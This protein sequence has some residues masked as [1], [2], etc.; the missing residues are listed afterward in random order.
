MRVLM[1]RMEDGMAS[2][3]SRKAATAVVLVGLLVFWCG[4]AYASASPSIAGF[5]AAPNPAASGGTVTVSASVSEAGECT[6]S[7]NKP[8][9]GLPVSFSCESGK[10]SQGVAM[11]EN[12]SEKPVK[13]KLTLTATGPGGHAKAHVS[14]SVDPFRPEPIFT[15][16]GYYFKPCGGRRV[17][18]SGDGTSAVWGHCTYSFNGEKWVH[19][20]TL[21]E[22]GR[23]AAIRPL[24]MSGDGR[25][26]VMYY[27][28]NL[29]EEVLDVFTR[30]SEEEEWTLQTMLVPP[31]EYDIP[32]EVALSGNGNTLLIGAF[33]YESGAKP[34]REFD[35]TGETWTEGVP[36]ATGADRCFGVALSGDGQTALLGCNGGGHEDLAFERSG[37]SWV[38]LG[39]PLKGSGESEIGTRVA[40][41]ANGDTALAGDQ[42]ANKDK[43][44][45][46][47][48]Q[49]V[50]N[51]FSQQGPSVTQPEKKTA[52]L[53]GYALALSADG[54][55][56]L[57]GAPAIV[58]VNRGEGHEPPK[59]YGAVYVYTRSGET[60]AYIQKIQ[61][62]ERGDEFG[63][64]LAL[65]E[66]GTM[67]LIPRYEGL[68]IYSG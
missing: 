17:V 12:T 60:W 22:L 7:A 56:A 68:Y 65:S 9:T 14:V 44:E 41:S 43:G 15:G 52:A 30:S 36:P 2:T 67:A 23:P 62:I 6:L 4:T 28:P 16:A 21:P 1:S 18:M 13:Y 34:L 5:T 49:R 42:Y 57:I 37:G 20:G 53:L 35:R 45:A 63:D 48:F 19:V 11:P 40:L 50:G 64:D 32:P 33:G 39:P 27:E 31:D 58:L 51:E 8:V 55:E 54:N 61:P 29:G 46:W 24:A 47:F 10:F 59:K 26:L 38:Q 66:S 3:S 25:T